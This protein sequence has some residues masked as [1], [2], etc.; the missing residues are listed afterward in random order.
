MAVVIFGVTMVLAE[1]QTK[2]IVDPINRLDPKNPQAEQVYDE[3][4]PL[5]RRLEKQKETIREQME[6]LRE[7]QEEFT[8]ITENMREGF[9]VVDSKADVISYNSSAVRILGVDMEKNGNGNINVLSLNRSNS[10]RQVVDEALAGQRCEQ[11][12]DLNGRHYQIIANPVAESENR[13]GAV[14]VILDVTEQQ[15]REGFAESLQQ[16]FLTS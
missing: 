16:M 8:A 15:N 13:W 10:F 12:L 6:T 4:A 1:L 5:V 2:R 7:K 9:I 3:L 14:V 11:N